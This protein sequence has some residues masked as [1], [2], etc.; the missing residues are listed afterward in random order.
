MMIYRQLDPGP[1]E[2]TL[3]GHERF[4]IKLYRFNLENYLR[5][6]FTKHLKQDRAMNKAVF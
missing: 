6:A 3:E 1:C 2:E 4:Q 5:I